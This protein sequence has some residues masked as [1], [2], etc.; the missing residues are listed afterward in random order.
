MRGRAT[1]LN[2]NDRASHQIRRRADL[3]LP[4]PVRVVDGLEEG[5]KGT[6]SAFEGP[7]PELRLFDDAAAEIGFVGT[8]IAERIDGGVAPGEILVRV[9]TVEQPDRAKAAVRAAGAKWASL[10]GRSEE[11]GERVAIG[12]MHLAKGLEARAVAV[13]ACDAEVIALQSRIGSAAEESELDEAFDSERHLLYVACTR[14][15][16]RAA[17]T[18]VRPGSEFLADLAD[19]AAR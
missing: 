11:G 5:R 15:R 9:R 7:E 3:L 8:W 13:M 4:V 19:T 6:I 18:G 14:A 1:T 10:A 12:E 16:D 17:V 2:V